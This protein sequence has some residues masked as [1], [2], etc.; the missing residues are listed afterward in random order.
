MSGDPEQDYFADGVVEDIITALSRFKSLFVIARNS[1]FTYKGKAAD[2]KQIG[3]ELGVRYVLEGS[4]RKAGGR[5]RITGQL[6][7]SVTGSHL[8]ADRFEGKLQDVF[9]LQDQV[10]AGVVG[11]LVTQVQF[12]EMERANRKRTESLDAYDCYLR[13]MAQVWKWT[14]PAIEAALAYFYRAIELDESFALAYACAGRMYTLRKQSHWMAD[15]TQESAVAVRLARRAIEL[16]QVD[17]MALCLGGFV[18]AY[19]GGELDFGAECIERGLSMNSNLAVGWTH[20]GWVRVYL[21]EHPTALEHLRQAKRLNP[22][23]PNMTQV[24][25]AAGF[26]HFFAGHYEET[27]RLAARITSEFPTFLPAWRIMAV[28]KALEGDPTWADKAA[29]KALELDPSARVSVFAA[30]QSR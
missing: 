30:R 8:W 12:A 15:I 26:A 24:R 9:D 2:I 11:Q 1:S 29:K 21:G 16:G 5:L 27:A 28:S 10:T 7:D 14:E 23:D 6:I 19:L 18:L 22:R 3:R 25:M 17:E 4:V 20:S 13:G